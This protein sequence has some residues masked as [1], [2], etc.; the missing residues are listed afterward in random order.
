[1]ASGRLR[2]LELEFLVKGVRRDPTLHFSVVSLASH[3]TPQGE[4]DLTSSLTIKIYPGTSKAKKEDLA[5]QT[6]K[7]RASL[8]ILNK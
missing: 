6:K 2:L 8:F 3:F 5:A 1:M 7:P 4:V